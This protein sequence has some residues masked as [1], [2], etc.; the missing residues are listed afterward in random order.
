MNHRGETIRDVMKAVVRMK[1]G[2]LEYRDVAPLTPRDGWIA[3]DIRA[4]SAWKSQGTV[5]RLVAAGL[6]QP[7]T[8]SS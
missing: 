6:L 4:M 2:R 8:R 7:A 5:H 1:P 3:I